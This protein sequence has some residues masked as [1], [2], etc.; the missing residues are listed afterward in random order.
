MHV[1]RTDLL[2]FSFSV[3]FHTVNK[4][5][6]NIMPATLELIRYRYTTLGKILTDIS[7]DTCKI[8]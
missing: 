5:P 7:L 3:P 8:R 4:S 2:T 1:P 6:K